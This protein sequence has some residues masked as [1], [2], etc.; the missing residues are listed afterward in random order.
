MS[1]CNMRPLSIGL[2][3]A[4][5]SGGTGVL[6]PALARTADLLLKSDWCHCRTYRE[7]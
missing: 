1:I 4:P 3:E 6:P 7:G 5:R 2:R